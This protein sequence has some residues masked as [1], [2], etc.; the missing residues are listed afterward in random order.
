[1][2]VMPW[3]AAMLLP[4]GNLLPIGV[5]DVLCEWLGGKHGMDSF[6]GRGTTEDKLGLET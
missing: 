5:R 6:V 4:L 3:A 1:M 2:L